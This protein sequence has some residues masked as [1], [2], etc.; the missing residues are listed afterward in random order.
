VR[1]L[2]ATPALA[3]R[4]VRLPACRPD[5]NPDEAIWAWVRTE[6]RHGR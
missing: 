5:F 2:L 6:Q 1:G 3:L 4:L